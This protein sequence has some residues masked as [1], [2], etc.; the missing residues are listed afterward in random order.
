[1]R[2]QARI[3]FAQRG[4]NAESRHH[5]NYTDHQPA[6][7]GRQ[8]GKAVATIEIDGYVWEIVETTIDSAVM[9]DHINNKQV[10]AFRLVCERPL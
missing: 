8:R 6:C 9:T 2:I 4:S 1:V 5:L 3:L 10:V 7:S